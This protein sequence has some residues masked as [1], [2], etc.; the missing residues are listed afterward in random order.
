[1]KSLV[2]D[3]NCLVQMISRH[4]PYRKIWDD[5][6]RRKFMLCVSNEIL[7]V[8]LSP[9]MPVLPKGGRSLASN[10]FPV[11]RGV[12]IKEKRNMNCSPF[13]VSFC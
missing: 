12:G 7:E 4:S 6:L 5:F 8:R 13:L 10:P 1:M 3:T 11:G 2:I 9:F